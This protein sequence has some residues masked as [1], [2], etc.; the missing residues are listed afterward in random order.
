MTK[1]KDVNRDAKKAANR[2]TVIIILGMIIL[3][4][5]LIAYFLLQTPQKTKEAAAVRLSAARVVES[6]T[7]THTSPNGRV[8]VTVEELPKGLMKIAATY[9]G[10][11]TMIVDHKGDGVDIKDSFEGIFRTYDT[12]AIINSTPIVGT[13][14]QGPHHYKISVVGPDKEGKMVE[15]FSVWYRV[16]RPL[17][18]RPFFNEQF[19]TK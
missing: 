10:A 18:E 13:I 14:R 15:M 16:E 9:P 8:N 5:A 19:T 2:Y 7:Y 4:V 12:A 11:S 3:F 1:H 17:G 6:N